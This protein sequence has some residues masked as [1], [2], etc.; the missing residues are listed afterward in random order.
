MDFTKGEVAMVLKKIE[1]AAKPKSGLA[2]PSVYP[3]GKRL[4]ALIDFNE[5]SLSSPAL[6]NLQRGREPCK[7]PTLPEVL[8]QCGSQRNERLQILSAE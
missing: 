4:L 3:S 6:K 2:L 8:R 5:L 1:S 7:P